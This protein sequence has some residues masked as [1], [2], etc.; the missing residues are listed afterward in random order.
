MEFTSAEKRVLFLVGAIQFVNIVDF[1]MVMPLG[2]DFTRDL[3]IPANHVGYIGGA[4]TLSACIGGFAGAFFLDR[5]GRRRAMVLS[6]LG[7]MLGTVAGAFAYDDHS[8]LI[9]RFV[10]GLF[11]GPAS[12][13]A[14]AV[15][16][17]VFSDEK[18]GRAMG[19]LGASFA[20]AAVLGVPFGL[21]LA[22]WGSWRWPFIAVA[23]A[24]LVLALAAM[25]LLPPLKDH[26]VGLDKSVG[27]RWQMIQA[28]MNR[29]SVWLAFGVVSL[30]MMA[31]FVIIPNIAVFLI[32]NLE[33]PRDGLPYVYLLG[34][35]VSFFGMRTSGKMVDKFGGFPV[36]LTVCCGTSAIIV[37]SFMGSYPLWLIYLLFP[38]FMLFQSARRTVVNTQVSKVPQP[39]ERAGFQSLISALQH[40]AC[41]IGA[42]LSSLLLVALPSGKVDGFGL[43]TMISVILTLMSPLMI[44]ALDYRLKIKPRPSAGPLDPGLEG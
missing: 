5:F 26:L 36:A 1:M 31:A 23:M 35:L 2:P 44:W 8:L 25:R 34:G 20:A 33:F 32:I 3:G 27:A 7:L 19:A 41:S 42:G 15:V 29:P 37:F 18:R 39:F 11:G 13:L 9:A 28:L 4:Y 38:A 30:D 40:L 6:L 16:S 17:D 21:Q 43:V 22:S 24:G 14:L 10:A 12:A